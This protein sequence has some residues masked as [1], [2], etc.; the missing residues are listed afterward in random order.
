MN[1]IHSLEN[2]L[3]LPDRV[4]ILV[5]KERTV[6]ELQELA[7]ALHVVLDRLHI[8]LVLQH[9]YYSDHQQGKGI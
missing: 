7:N 5:W 4:V 3:L 2:Q 1:L 8:E 9:A 6:V